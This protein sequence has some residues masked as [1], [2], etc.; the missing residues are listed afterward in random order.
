LPGIGRHASLIVF[1]N[2]A[3]RFRM[4]AKLSGESPQRGDL[5][6]IN[7]VS[8]HAHLSSP[9]GPLHNLKPRERSTISRLRRRLIGSSVS[10][11]TQI[12]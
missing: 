6:E 2:S 1:S 4:S 7:P 11:A 12:T 8:D 5:D 9:F 3:I 10:L